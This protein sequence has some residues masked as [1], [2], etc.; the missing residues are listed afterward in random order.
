MELYSE[1]YADII[2]QLDIRIILDFCFSCS[3][4][5][6]TYI[7][8]C[9]I[10]IWISLGEN[11]QTANPHTATLILTIHITEQLRGVGQSLIH[12]A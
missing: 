1:D 11:V 4:T 9:R 6:L 12:I 7:Q 3:P 10:P 5:V 2:L 8:F